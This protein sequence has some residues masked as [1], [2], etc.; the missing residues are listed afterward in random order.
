MESWNIDETGG[1]GEGLNFFE[2]PLPRALQKPP[3]KRHRKI[4]SMPVPHPARNILNTRSGFF[5]QMAGRLQADFREKSNDGLAEHLPEELFE[6]EFVDGK[7]PAQ[8]PQSD[9]FAI[10]VFQVIFDFEHGFHVFGF[11]VGCPV[12]G[13]DCA[14][15][16][17]FLDGI[18][19]S[20]GCLIPDPSDIYPEKLSF[21][22]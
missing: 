19:R 3:F 2:P 18:K 10:M 17:K 9:G 5:Q 21:M 6:F 1:V 13:I 12:P 4:T 11:Q 8:S 20:V 16:G 22:A 7:F 15:G 14:L